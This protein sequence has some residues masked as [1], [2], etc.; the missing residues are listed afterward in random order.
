[1]PFSASVDMMPVLGVVPT[2]ALIAYTKILA[3]PGAELEQSVARELAANPALLQ[4]EVGSC[5]GCGLPADDPCPYCG[6]AA[7]RYH[8]PAPHG[9]LGPR[10]G[11]VPAASVTWP[12]ALLADL[13]LVLPARDARIASVVVASLDDQG[14]LTEDASALARMAGT[15]TA[16]ADRVVATLRETAPP[17]VGARDLRDCLLMQLDRKTAEGIAQPVARAVVADHLAA[18]ARGATATIARR[19]GVAEDEVTRARAFI[20]RELLPRPDIHRGAPLTGPPRVAVKPDVAVFRLPGHP[21]EFRVDVLEERRLLLHVDP[22]FRRA[23]KTDNQV[24]QWVRTGDFFLARL[25]ERWSTLKRLTEHLLAQRPDLV[26][27]GPVTDRRLTQAEVAAS[28]GLNP[29]TVSRAVAGKYVMLPSRRVLP[30]SEFFDGS[31]AVRARLEAILAA[32]DRP[33]TDS[34]L[35]ERL[36]RAGHCVARRTVA[37]YRSRLRVLPSAYR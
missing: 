33:L 34:E 26:S 7:S 24:M 4:D 25:R 20:R 31:R 10:L 27:G 15:D 36:H 5:G 30:F 3:L 35:T 22:L 37:K 8:G 18:L 19:L 6:E 12:D 9:Q 1:M 17:G 11:G 32:E 28:L 23:A 14:Y 16:G 13:M 2:P 29:S 21:A